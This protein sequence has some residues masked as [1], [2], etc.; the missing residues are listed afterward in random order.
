MQPASA[1]RPL[2]GTSGRA[3]VMSSNVAANA[4]FGKYENLYQ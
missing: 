4:V 3:S 1:T 2:G